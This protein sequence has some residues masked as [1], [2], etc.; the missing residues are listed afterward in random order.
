MSEGLSSHITLSLPPKYLFVKRRQQASIDKA[1]SPGS[2]TGPGSHLVLWSTLL[3]L[4]CGWHCHPT[5]SQPCKKL[6]PRY[7][8]LLLDHP[9]F[10]SHPSSY[11]ASSPISPICLC[12]YLLIGATEYPTSWSPCL[13]CHHRPIVRIFKPPVPQ[14]R[15]AVSNPLLD[16]R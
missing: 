3:V 6:H 4:S 16:P 14:F 7:Y 5:R 9:S 13:S 11:P 1:L 8:V 2:S 12:P 15:H 10:K